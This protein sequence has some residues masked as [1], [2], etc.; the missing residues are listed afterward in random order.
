MKVK[1]TEK[2]MKDYFKTFDLNGDG[3]IKIC[4]LSLVMKVFGGKSYTKEEI[5]DMFDEA[6]VN[7]DGKA[8]YQGMTMC[9]KT[10]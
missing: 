4:E 7:H 1:S 10:N 2:D 3:L 5:H 9:R 8:T 6:D